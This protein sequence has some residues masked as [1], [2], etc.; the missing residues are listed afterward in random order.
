MQLQGNHT[1]WAAKVVEEGTREE[2]TVDHTSHAA[3]LTL[4]VPWR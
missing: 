4:S 2:L 1:G 3:N